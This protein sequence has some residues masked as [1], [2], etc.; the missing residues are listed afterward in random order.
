MDAALT[1]FGKRSGETTEIT[2]Q[3]AK[4]ILDLANIG[5]QCYE[6]EDLKK[7]LSVKMEQVQR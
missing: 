3:L 5:L 7:L 1:E 2:E 6:W 4:L